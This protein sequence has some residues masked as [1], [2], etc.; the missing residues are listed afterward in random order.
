M[1]KVTKGL[2]LSVTA[3]FA[4]EKDFKNPIPTD[5]GLGEFTEAH[6]SHLMYVCGH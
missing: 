1:C 5:R 4:V 6:E 2:E 3:W